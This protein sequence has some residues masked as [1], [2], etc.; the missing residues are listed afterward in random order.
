MA[1]WEIYFWSSEHHKNTFENLNSNNM[2][3]P[4][5]RDLVTLCNPQ[6]SSAVSCQNYFLSVSSHR[7]MKRLSSICRVKRELRSTAKIELWTVP[8]ACTP[9]ESS[10]QPLDV[11]GSLPASV[12]SSRTFRM[13][14]VCQ[15]EVRS[16]FVFWAVAPVSVITRWG[17][18]WICCSGP[19]G[20]LKLRG[21]PTAA[22]AESPFWTPPTGLHRTETLQADTWKAHLWRWKKKTNPI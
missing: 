22:A 13:I 10:Q 12:V 7:L 2:F 20:W 19:I 1:V 9:V 17:W 16:G 4:R 15:A 8:L 6:T 3:L 11:I 14:R 5:N 21:S 18:G